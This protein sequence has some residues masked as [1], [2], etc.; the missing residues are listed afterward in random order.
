LFVCYFPEKIVSRLQETALQVQQAE[1]CM[2]RRPKTISQ[3]SLAA[4]KQ[5]M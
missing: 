2:V 5:G 3:A 4:L 1:E